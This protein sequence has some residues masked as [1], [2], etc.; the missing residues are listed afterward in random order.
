MNARCCEENETGTPKFSEGLLYHR[1]KGLRFHQTNLSWFGASTA[2]NARDVRHHITIYD[3][4][5]EFCRV[6]VKLP[7]DSFLQNWS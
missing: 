2:P 7:L 6:Y 1:R 5:K 3:S 4:L